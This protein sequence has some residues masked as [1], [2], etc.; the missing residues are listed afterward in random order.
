[1]SAATTNKSSWKGVVRLDPLI[2]LV[3]AVI[4][5]WPTPGPSRSSTF[6]TRIR[7][8]IP[9]LLLPLVL[10]LRISSK[11][12]LGKSSLE[13]LSLFACRSYHAGDESGKG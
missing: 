2:K 8:G 9:S 3:A 1:M 6:R 5:S 4:R 11:T 12:V 7:L 13:I 10:L